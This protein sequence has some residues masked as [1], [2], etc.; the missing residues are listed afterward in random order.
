MVASTSKARAW[1]HSHPGAAPLLVVALALAAASQARAQWMSPGEL[2]RAHG[3]LDHDDACGKCHK[4]GHRVET[5]LCTECHDDIGRQRSGGDGLHGG[6]FRKQDCGHCH[7]EHRGKNHKLIRWPGGAKARFEHDITGFALRGMHAGTA[8]GDCHTKKNRRGAQTLLGLR[9]EC[10]ACHAER[11]VHRG[12]MGDDCG[13]CHNARSW[14]SAKLDHFDHDRA[15]FKLKGKHSDLVCSACHHDPPRYRNIPFESC[16]SCHRDPHRGR[17]GDDCKSCHNESRFDDV[18]MQRGSHPGLSLGGG[19][20]RV[21]CARCHDRGVR[22]APSRGNRC[23]SCHEPVH[24]APFGNDC[25]SCHHS[26]RWLGL[27]ERIGRSAHGLTAFALEGRHQGVACDQCHD[28]GHPRPERFRQLQ[29]QH[30]RDCHED[31]HGGKLSRYGDGD[32]KSCHDVSGFRPT[33]FSVEQHAHADFP[34]IGRHVAVPCASCHRIE[35]P[36]LDFT[37]EHQRCA[38]CHENPHGRQF[39]RE[40]RE[41]GCGSCHNPVAWNL[42]NIDHSTWPLQGAHGLVAC[43][44]CHTPSEDDRR[45]GSGASYRG[46]PRECEGCHRDPHLGQFRL[47]EPLR[48]CDFC[49][50]NTHFAIERFDHTGK[51]GYGL[52]GKHAELEC[53]ACHRQQT[54]RNGMET[55]RHRL[56]YRNCKDCHADPHTEAGR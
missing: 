12:R 35:P 5:A 55:T 47:S 52:E 23:V 38:D 14:T 20:T 3:K 51:A 1:R 46:V 48:R 32:C 39:E 34:L 25:K 15:R 9:S 42:P 31:A 2:A 17:L 45:A 6:R 56:G 18:R 37:L 40:L 29:F 28:P 49:H 53:A 27:P 54:L 33:R 43:A 26:I 22:S 30:C 11:D 8:C 21:D 36:R 50:G 44:S 13:S 4:S 24:E 16:Q 19:H 7:V 41:G 10:K